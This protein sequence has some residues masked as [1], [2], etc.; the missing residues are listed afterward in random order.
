MCTA[1]PQMHVYRIMAKTRP[2][3]TK[4]SSLIIRLTFETLLNSI[5]SYTG[6]YILTLL[7][8]Y[9]SIR[10]NKTILHI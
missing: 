10:S 3:C 1:G 9:I 6:S 5:V 7:E 2:S 4:M 8:Y